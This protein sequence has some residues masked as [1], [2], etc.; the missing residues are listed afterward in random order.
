VT[1][2]YVYGPP[3]GADDWYEIIGVVGDLAMNVQNPM[4][5]A[6]VYHPL[7]LDEFHPMRYIIEVGPDAAGFAP[8]LAQIAYAVDPDAIVQAPRVI[9]DIAEA[10]RLEERIASALILTLALIG[11]LIAAAGLYAL[12]SFTVSQRT[13][14]IG[15]RTALGARPVSVLGTIARRAALQ[16]GAGVLLGCVF[17]TWLMREVAGDVTLLDVNIPAVLGGVGVAVVLMVSAA[18][19]SPIRRGLRIQPTEALKES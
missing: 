13:R 15:I 5:D 17:G 2:Q 14:E 9:A 4:R 12:M 11:T 16:L 8:R 3:V 10:N 19:L 1:G 18:C 6:G 7:G